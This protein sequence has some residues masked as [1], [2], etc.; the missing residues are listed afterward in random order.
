MNLAHFSGKRKAHTIGNSRITF[1]HF[2]F[3]ELF[4]ITI[5]SWFTSNNSGRIISRN[6]SDLHL[7]PRLPQHTQSLH[8][9]IL[10]ELFFC[11]DFMSITSKY[12][13]GIH[14]VI[15]AFRMVNINFLAWLPLD[16]PGLVPGTY[17]VCPWDKPTLSQ[18]QTQDFTLSSA[19][20]KAHVLQVY[21]SFFRS[22][23]SGSKDL[24][25]CLGLHCLERTCWIVLTV[26]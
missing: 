3:R 22:L 17:P 18:G 24:C 14:I 7:L 4:L 19:T 13:R 16:D 11:K 12:S 2:I 1:H 9:K 5:S 8:Q 23:T 25:V 6:L 26:E 10:G 20:E 15:L 21:V